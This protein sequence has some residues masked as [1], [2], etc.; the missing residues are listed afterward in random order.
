MKLRKLGRT[1]LKVSNLCL[2]TMTFGNGQWGCDEATS[3]KI[4]HRFLDAGGNFV[5]TA[6]GDVLRTLAGAPAGFEPTIWYSIGRDGAI[7]VN[8]IRAEL[9]QIEVLRRPEKRGLGNA[10]RAMENQSNPWGMNQGERADWA[11]GLDV[12]IVDPGE[13][14]TEEYLYWVGCA[15]SFD[16]KNKKVAT[17]F[18]LH[19]VLLIS[20]FAYL[21]AI[22]AFF[23][24][25]LPLGIVAGPRICDRIAA[26]FVPWQE[27][28]FPGLLTNVVAGRVASR[29]DLHGANHTT[30]A[31]CA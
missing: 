29:F 30:D 15:G 20:G 7:T 23:A 31:A 6:D 11:K 8:I 21:L 2:G 4:V 14:F 22:P 25:L 3:H 28:T 1:G 26:G 18:G 17:S 13:P 16:D 27:E 12:K 9:G 10:Y 24:V 5:D 19:A